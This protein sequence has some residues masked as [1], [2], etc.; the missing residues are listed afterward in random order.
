MKIELIINS[1]MI[2][3]E[4][5]VRA[6]TYISDTCLQKFVFYKIYLITMRICCLRTGEQPPTREGVANGPP[7]VWQY[8][9]RT[10]A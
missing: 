9:P 5:V 1:C 7:P 2:Y 6:S 4:P 3:Y 8:G 10:P